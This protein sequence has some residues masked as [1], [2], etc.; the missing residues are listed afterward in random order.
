MSGSIFYQPRIRLLS[1]YFNWMFQ[2]SSG[3]KW[4]KWI[5]VVMHYSNIGEDCSSLPVLSSLQSSNLEQ[6]PAIAGL[7]WTGGLRVFGTK[8]KT[9]HMLI[10]SSLVAA[11]FS[12]HESWHMATQM[13]YFHEQFELAHLKIVGLSRQTKKQTHTCV[14]SAGPASVR[15]F[16]ARSRWKWH[17]WPCIISL[18]I[19]YRPFDSI[20]RPSASNIQVTFTQD[21]TCF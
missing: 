1:W 2:L 21:V 4:R 12:L 16:Q 15:F 8:N 5:F 3:Q 19:A 6:P 7:D 20:W 18:S 14:H 9:L 10:T 11:G 13:F 17:K